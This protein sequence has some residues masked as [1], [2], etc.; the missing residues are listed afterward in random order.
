[1]ASTGML[2]KEMFN[3]IS[4]TQ[5]AMQQNNLQEKGSLEETLPQPRPKI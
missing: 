2:S 1:M 5:K 4:S 3:M